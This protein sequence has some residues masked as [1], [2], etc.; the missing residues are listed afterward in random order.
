MYDYAVLASKVG[1]STA[2]LRVFNR[3]TRLGL[4]AIR[5]KSVQLKVFTSRDS[6]MAGLAAAAR[7]LG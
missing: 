4:W 7:P 2:P 5:I 1:I 6:C 3:P